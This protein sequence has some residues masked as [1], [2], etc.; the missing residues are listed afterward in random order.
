MGEM[1]TPTE[2]QKKALELLKG[3]AKHVLLFGGSRSGKTTVLVM[4]I[5]YR[6]AAFP[7]SRHL[8]CR[9]R[10]KDARSSVLHETLIPWL[11]KTIGAKNYKANVHDGL[12][13]LWNGS[14]IWIGGLGDKEQVDRI[15]GHEYVTIYFNE[16]S[17]ISYSAITTAYSR[18]AMK[19]EGCKNK[20]FY[21]CNPCSPMHWAYKVFIRKI[22]PRTDEKL[23][24]PELYDSTILNPMDNAENLDEDYIS[25][26]LD[27]MPEK[28]RARFRDGLWVKPDGS[29]YE[30][31]EES[32]ILRREELPDEFD[33][34]TGGQDF[35]LHI[36]AVKIGWVGETVYVIADSGGF[37]ITTK[38]S[39]EQQQAKHWYDECFVTYC[40]PAGG[41]RIQEVPGGVKANNSVD[42][43]IDYIIAKI[44]R[45]QFFVCKDC[46]GVLGEIWD[47]SRDENNQIIKVNDH[48]MD[49]M[50]YAIFSAV[51]SGVVMR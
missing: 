48:Y 37:N 2:V 4:A 32:M 17:Q 30:K 27:N 31:F 6:A 51:T 3:E 49:A 35:G 22:E 9:Y 21:D 41:E 13:T 38:T 5:I 47:Y 20:F 44:E 28:Q 18:L 42:A 34:Y 7:G 11:N 46:T 14:E 50:R 10:A 39:V 19:V 8:I 26:I 36:A 15:L 40:D 43:G 12:I 29:I 25:D 16:V 33:K 45:G 23:L 1:F 24:K